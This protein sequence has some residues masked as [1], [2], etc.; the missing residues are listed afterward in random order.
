MRQTSIGELLA[1][2]VCPV[3][4][5]ATRLERLV[6]ALYPH[7]AVLARELE[8]TIRELAS[9]AADL[10]CIGTDD[11][12]APRPDAP[13]NVIL[14]YLFARWPAGRTSFQRLIARADQA[15]GRAALL[16]RVACAH[17]RDSSR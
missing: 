6:P 9:T 4:D 10:D 11:P 16:R 8:L 17:V 13:A 1:S 2:D 3:H 7:D 14:G 12:A 5:W 15:L